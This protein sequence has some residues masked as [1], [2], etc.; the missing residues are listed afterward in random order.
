MALSISCAVNQ[1]IKKINL[2]YSI[3]A[4]Q[5]EA[6][7]YILEGKDTL[8]ILPTSIGKSL[9]YQLLPEVCR[10]LEDQSCNPVVLVVSPLKALINDQVKEANNL[11]NSLGLSACTISTSNDLATA[12]KEKHNMLFGIPEVWLQPSIKKFLSGTYFRDNIVCVIVDE[13]HKVATW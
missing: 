5:L 4:R 3:K 2:S 10:L 13:A 9:I 7:T 8:A 12:K 1:S 6:I 11:N